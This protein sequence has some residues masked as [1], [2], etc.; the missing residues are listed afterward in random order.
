VWAINRSTTEGSTDELARERESAKNRNGG[1]TALMNR[2]KS[3]AI[4]LVRAKR[5]L[6]AL[7]G[8]ERAAPGASERGNDRVI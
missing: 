5:S 6:V 3:H 7:L 4:A 1:K 2:P 8:G